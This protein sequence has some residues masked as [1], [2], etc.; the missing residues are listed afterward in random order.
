MPVAMLSTSLLTNPQK[1]GRFNALDT[2]YGWDFELIREVSFTD[3]TSV[4][5]DNI[6]TTDYDHYLITSNA[7][8]TT[9]DDQ[10]FYI[11]M[12][13]NGS[14]DSTNYRTQ[15]ISGNGTSVVANGGAA[16]GLDTALGWLDVD[17]N[18]GSFALC[19]MMYPALANPTIVWTRAL[20]FLGGDG[21]R[22]DSSGKTHT[23]ASAQDGCEIYGGTGM[24]GSVFFYGWRV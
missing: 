21:I 3:V 16:T 23:V 8:A 20:R 10:N 4:V 15:Y 9:T 11:R 12:R 14:T 6:F 19:H 2:E 13:S 18:G 22:W 7:Y 5:V 24:T 1:Y 17:T